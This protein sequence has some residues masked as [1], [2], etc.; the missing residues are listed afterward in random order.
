M[1]TISKPIEELIKQ[2]HTVSAFKKTAQSGETLAQIQSFIETLSSPFPAKPTVKVINAEADGVKLGKVGSV[3]GATMFVGATVPNVPYALEAIGYELE[4]LVLFL[5]S[6]GLGTCWVA[7]F[8]RK[9]FKQAM[10]ASDSD[11][12]P[13][14]L[15]FGSAGKSLFGGG[16]S[17]KREA[18]IKLFFDKEFIRALD[19]VDAGAYQLPLEMVR[20][21]PSAKNKQPWRVVK[22][23]GQYHFFDY[24]L[25]PH[26]YPYDFDVHAIDMGIAA[27]HFHLTA[28]D[29]GLKGEFTFD[30]N[31]VIDT[32]PEECIYKFSWTAL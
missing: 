21:A 10:G 19:E 14:V 4:K 17:R 23:G 1:T 22:T 24:T 12:L 27:C 26:A 2:R 5:T 11:L 6:L 32:Q 29:K 7:S 28:L 3:S 9:A 20:L 13:V 16:G 25:P 15:A 8:D 31:P 30:V 18:W